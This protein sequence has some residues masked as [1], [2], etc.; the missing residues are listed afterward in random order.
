MTPGVCKHIKALWEKHKEGFCYELL[1]PPKPIPKY[2][3]LSLIPSHELDS[4]NTSS[5]QISMA[6]AHNLVQ[7]FKEAYN[8]S[9][10]I[11]SSPNA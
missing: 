1:V 5:L 9:Y 4:T 8:H 7:K 11:T 10:H 3:H 6:G 2:W